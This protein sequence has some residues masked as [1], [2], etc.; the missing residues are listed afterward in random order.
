MTDGETSL[1][2]RHARRAHD[3]RLDLSN[4]QLRTWPVEVSSL[5]DLAE[6][7]LSRN[8]LNS[9]DPSLS[10]LANLEVLNLSGNQL[11]GFADLVEAM[12]GLERLRSLILDG[13]PCAMQLSPER[14]R[15][16]QNP[17]P[18]PGSTPAQTI[19]S[20]L[21]GAMADLGATMGFGSAASTLGGG[22]GSLGGGSLGSGG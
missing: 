20:I 17:Q 9:V 1:A 14:L 12:S 13:N 18:K 2:I 11:I 7:D 8:A 22:L 19:S 6:L 4:R 16:L 21:Q 5:S 15:E 10:Q 3:K